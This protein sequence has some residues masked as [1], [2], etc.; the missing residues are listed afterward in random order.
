ME[1]LSDLT[2]GLWL[3]GTQV[4]VLKH[5]LEFKNQQIATLK[6][7]AAQAPQPQP[8]GE[9]A[10]ARL[11]RKLSKTISDATPDEWLQLVQ[12][13]QQADPEYRV[14]TMAAYQQL[15]AQIATALK[16]LP[17]SALCSSLLHSYTP[18]GHIGLFNTVAIPLHPLGDPPAPCLA[19]PSPPIGSAD[20]R[21]S[22]PV[23]HT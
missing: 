14:E 13:A 2:V 12:A 7:A 4:A 15:C 22:G 17:L 10:A 6:A 18:R 21:R 16:V 8:K 19:H 20:E 5:E 23:P 11:R 1:A 9:P 3:Y